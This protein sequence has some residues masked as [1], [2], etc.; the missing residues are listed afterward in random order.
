[1]YT[2]L[3]AWLLQFRTQLRPDIRKL[4]WTLRL[5]TTFQW[6][7]SA[8]SLRHS[9]EN[10]VLTV[11][12]NVYEHAAITVWLQT[13]D[14]D[15]LTNASLK[16]PTLI[17]CNPIKPEIKAEVRRLGP[18][19]AAQLPSESVSI[20]ELPPPADSNVA[21]PGPSTA[22]PQAAAPASPV[23]FLPFPKPLATCSQAADAVL[24]GKPQ[25]S[26]FQSVIGTYL[27]SQQASAEHENN[28]KY[29]ATRFK[30]PFS[31]K[32]V[33]IYN[34][35]MHKLENLSAQVLTSLPELRLP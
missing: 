34:H 1:M 25:V 13:H 20:C 21:I 12:G 3:Q 4:L 28:P 5:A 14:T 35:G 9:C 26:S 22:Q 6:R 19:A 18:K 16:G 23:Y 27:Q 10:P 32:G 7:S 31:M 33:R 17:P 15:P 24:H 30:Y 11:Q 29:K 8:Q 2:C